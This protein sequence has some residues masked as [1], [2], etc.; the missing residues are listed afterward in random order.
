[1]VSEV[2]KSVSIIDAEIEYLTYGQSGPHVVMLHATGS[3]PWLWQ[4]VAVRLSERFRVVAPAMYNHRQTDPEKGGLG[5]LD[6][7]R[8]LKK[9]TE[10][11]GLGKSLFVGHSMGAAVIMLAHTVLGMPVEK[12][13]LIE[14]VFFPEAFYTFEMKLQQN[15]MA[16]RAIKRRNHW[17]DR[18]TVR[19][20]F[21][22]KPFF[23]NWDEE[24][25]S[26]Y[27]TH[28]TTPDKGSGFRL[29]CS[30]Q[31]EAALFMGGN[32]HDPW[33]EL[34]KVA[35]PSM[36]VEGQ[37]SDHRHIIDLQK[38]TNLIP[39]ARYREVAGAGHLVPMEKPLEV[40]QLI[41]SFFSENTEG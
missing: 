14:P 21:L 38:V 33:P 4:P 17:P 29:A 31:Q 37:V 36:V 20:D 18:A 8:D 39:Q 35:C 40:M 23:Q 34:P 5:W 9:L 24:V 10:T 6:L 27:V 26:L 12:M 15:P 11:L 30:P 16:A 19:E 7:A 41:Q 13:V 25:L 22:S 2:V 1:M 32:Q 28:G 3:I